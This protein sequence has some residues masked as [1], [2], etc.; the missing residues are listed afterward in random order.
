MIL[1]DWI[2][3]VD[4]IV[5]VVIWENGNTDE[6]LFEGAM[7]DIPWTLV[8]YDIGRADKEDTDEPIYIGTHVN[9][10]GN[11]VTVVTINIITS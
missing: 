11:E 3:Q 4:P 1:K 6:P 7:F 8:E 2:K 10:Y 9:K 5:D